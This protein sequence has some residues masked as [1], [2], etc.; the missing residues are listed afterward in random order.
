MSF[1]RLPRTFRAAFPALASLALVALSACG[2]V[3][4]TYEAQAPDGQEGTVTIEFLDDD[5]AKLTF[6]S[7]DG[8]EMNFTGTSVVE[9]DTVTLTGPDGDKTT[10]MVKGNTLEGDFF[11]DKVVFK[12]K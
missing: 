12:K 1:T 7:G 3:S 2:G 10:F 11:G 4:G 9:D 8:A 5:K 6:S